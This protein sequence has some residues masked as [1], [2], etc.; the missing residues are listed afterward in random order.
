MNIFR[1]DSKEFD[2]KKPGES[3]P[4]K[5]ATEELRSHEK[6]N[7]DVLKP[8]VTTSGGSSQY[9]DR[10]HD[11]GA[12]TTKISK[13]VTG[14]HNVLPNALDTRP[15][16]TISQC[17]L[18]C[19][20]VTTQGVDN[21]HGM[22]SHNAPDV[23]RPND[24]L[25]NAIDTSRDVVFSTQTESNSQVMNQRVTEQNTAPS[26]ANIAKHSS[27][28]QPSSV[29]CHSSSN[30]TGFTSTATPSISL[31]SETKV[32]PQV[33]P[34]V[35]LSSPSLLNTVQ[36]S[37]A[38][39][40]QGNVTAKSSS[41]I[42]NEKNNLTNDKIKKNRR[43]REILNVPCGGADDFF[44]LQQYYGIIPF[45]STDTCSERESSSKQTKTKSC[46]TG[47][48]GKTSEKRQDHPAETVY[49]QNTSTVS[50]DKETLSTKSSPSDVSDVQKESEAH[51][52]MRSCIDAPLA[53]ANKADA[54]SCAPLRSSTNSES[55]LSND[56]Q[57]ESEAGEPEVMRSCV[58]TPLGGANKA[59]AMSCIPLE[60][61]ANS[62]PSRLSNDWHDPRVTCYKDK[63]AFV[64]DLLFNNLVQTDKDISLSDKNEYRPQLD[65]SFTDDTVIIL[66]DQSDVHG[67]VFVENTVPTDYRM[68]RKRRYISSELPSFSDDDEKEEAFLGK[69]NRSMGKPSEITQAVSNGPSPHKRPALMVSKA[70]DM[71]SSSNT[72]RSLAHGKKYIGPQLKFTPNAKFV[73][74]MPENIKPD[75]T[76]SY[77]STKIGE[78]KKCATESFGSKNSEEIIPAS[79][80]FSDRFFESSDDDESLP[81]INITTCSVSSRKDKPSDT[82]IQCRNDPFSVVTPRTEI[83]PA[84]K[85]TDQSLVK[86]STSRLDSSSVFSDVPVYDVQPSTSQCEANVRPDERENVNTVLAVLPHLDELTVVRKLR[87]Y[88]G[89]VEFVVSI[90]L[91]ES[92]I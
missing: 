65:L 90:L 86:P 81:E 66:P 21:S 32:Q 76:R 48:S 46:S 63:G 89:N 38:Y 61:S 53:G 69:E 36:P 19:T 82:H 28:S 42:V 29:K 59:A 49:S 44:Y 3:G 43:S 54:M 5:E 58:D 7:Q 10:S 88:E 1:V 2:L 12:N 57:K 79:S 70:A 16:V 85:F 91:D 64:D 41:T 50:I 51:E 62:E 4:A 37:Q 40:T 55:R 72:C 56:C 67:P 78:I 68:E 31:D 75:H 87:L 23:V 17:V 39:V 20:N 83:P 11:V 24:V 74:S 45:A 22:I 73:N 35:D 71:N 13:D 77:R 25:S 33:I 6:S 9:P 14:L 80:D 8:A 92:F 47:M 26:T 27:S 84:K 15:N 60:S 34:I 52:I 18:S 30:S